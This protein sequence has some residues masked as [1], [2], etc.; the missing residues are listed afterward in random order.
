MPGKDADVKQWAQ[1][2][3]P[4]LEEHLKLAQTDESIA[5]NE[6]K[7]GTKTSSRT[8]TSKTGS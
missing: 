8:P 5:K 7:S 3:L 1:K 4:V 2:T 6:A